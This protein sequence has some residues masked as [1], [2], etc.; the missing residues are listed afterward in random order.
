MWWV[1][2]LARDGIPY[3]KCTLH[4]SLHAKSVTI[5]T[6]KTITICSLY[7]PPSEN[8]SIVLFSSLIDHLPTPFIECGDSITWG[9]D[10]NDS[11]RDRIDF[12]TDRIAIYVYLMM[13]LINIC[14]RLQEDAQAL[15]FISVL[16]TFV[17]T[18]ISWL[19]RTRIVVIIFLLFKL[20]FRFRMYY[21]VGILVRLTGCN[22]IIN[23]KKN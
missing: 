14:T 4:T 10:K 16:R 6:S 13:V 1:S 19:N 3:S 7:L 9:C 22:S 2:V 15:I 23:V 18:L 5:S 17:W 11:R 20:V 21:T 8:L 12:I